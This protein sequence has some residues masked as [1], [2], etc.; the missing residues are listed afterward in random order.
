MRVYLVGCGKSKRATPSRAEDLYIGNLVSKSIKYASL[1]SKREGADKYILSAKWGVLPFDK[2]IAPYDKTLKNMSL[3]EKRI[4]SKQ[5]AE[6]LKSRGYD[7][8]K[9]EF[10]VLAGKDYSEFLVDFYLKNYRLFFG[11]LPLGKRGQ[12]I[13]KKLMEVK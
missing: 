2:V 1:M 13:N 11:S 7:L 6:D 3:K 4:W 5:V 10:I 8:E 12:F 9:D